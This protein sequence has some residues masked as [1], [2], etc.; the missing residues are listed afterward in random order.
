MRR[1]RIS[2][3]GIVKCVNRRLEI[4]LKNG[5]IASYQEVT[6]DDVFIEN[7]DANVSVVVDAVAPISEINFDID[8]MGDANERDDVS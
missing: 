8:L 7:G 6:L 1:I 2:K 4:M 5:E 3:A